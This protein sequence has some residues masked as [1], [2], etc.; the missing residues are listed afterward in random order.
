MKI[1]KKRLWNREISS[2]K[3]KEIT[4]NHNNQSV[5]HRSFVCCGFH[6]Y[7]TKIFWIRFA[8]QCSCCLHGGLLPKKKLTKWV[9]WFR[10]YH[11]PSYQVEL[12]KERMETKREQ[13]CAKRTH[14]FELSIFLGVSSTGTGKNNQKIDGIFSS[15]RAAKQLQ[16]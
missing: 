6:D 15:H 13:V 10:Y 14:R 9:G 7:L 12:E 11:L 2:K 8:W 4:H 3:K 16:Q 1:N 5:L